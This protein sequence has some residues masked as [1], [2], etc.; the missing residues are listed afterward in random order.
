MWR[1][2]HRKF[3]GVRDIS[4]KMCSVRTYVHF[5][6]LKSRA[7]ESL[8]NFPNVNNG[9]KKCCGFDFCVYK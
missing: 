1:M 8:E 6:S 3:S 7:K 2:L 9:K 4:I 5:N